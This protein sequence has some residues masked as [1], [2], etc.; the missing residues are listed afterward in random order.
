MSIT[1][2]SLRKEF[3]VPSGVE[4]A[5]DD[6]DLE[7]RDDEFMS[8]VGPSGCGKTTTLRCVAGLEQPTSGTIEL[9]GADVT[10]I[11][12]NR[13]NIAMMFQ[14]IALYPH[15]TIIDNISYPLKVRD[16]DKET[17]YEEAREAAEV[18][19]IEELL[20]KHPGELSGGQRQR[21]ALARTLVQDPVAFL[22]D[23]PLSDL[24]AKLKI[25][26]RKVIQ[27][28]HTRVQK[29][30][31]Y[32]THD[33]EEAMTMSDRIAIMNDGILEQ[34]GTPSECYYDP[35]NRF[36]A[37][38]IGSPS[39]NFADGEV[40][41]VKGH[42]VQ[43]EINGI[44]FEIISDETQV[45]PGEPIEV[46][47]RPESVLLG[48]EVDQP[49]FHAEVVL[50]EQLGNQVVATLDNP[51]EEGEIRAIT[52]V[53]NNLSEGERV[54]IALDRA[55]LFLF[56]KETGQKVAISDNLSKEVKAAA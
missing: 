51:V 24:D 18:L 54:P 34:V 26:I 44:E 17:R 38:F 36:V 11:P 43:F 4:V 7:I 14:D 21:A 1:I 8:L 25:E 12:A 15:M 5:V 30:T 22:M 28:I 29:P 9:A 2:N 48:E 3:S 31:L 6:I 20:D 10:D 40:K 16:I 56:N 19:Q 53:G 13:R 27:R 47:F 39:I 55:Q 50:I 45:S 46:G 52:S 32:V 41:S 42:N 37:Q 33:Q 49:D 35:E 23:E